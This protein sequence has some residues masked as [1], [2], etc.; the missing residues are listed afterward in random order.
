MPDQ[1]ASER[2]EQA[3]PERL[4]KAR[5]EGQVPLSREVPSALMIGALLILLSL[6]AGRLYRWFV[7]QVSGGFSARA[8][9]ALGSTHLLAILRDEAA[10]ML[11]VLL[12]FLA[13]TA[14]VSVFASLLSSGWTFA[15]K[16]VQ[17]RF[18]RISPVR[19]LKNLFSAR[20][21]VR[22]VLSILKLVFL[23]VIVYLYLRDKLGACYALRW[24]TAAGAVAGMAQLVFGLLARIALGILVIAAIDL[25]YQR[26]K[27]KRDLRMTKQEVKEERRQYELSPEVKGRIRGVQIEMVRR[28][29]LQEVPKA[30]VVLTNP[31]HVAV[32]L[33]YDAERM[34]A[35]QVVAKGA[36][37]L[38]EKIKEI[39]RAHRV[40]IRHRPE[41]A[42]ALYAT[43]EVG[44]PI[45]EA[46]FVAV[47]EILAMI[48]R[49]RKQRS[50]V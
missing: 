10:E 32:A 35:P 3:T 40:P 24:T 19:G 21:V 7:V 25:L 20:S 46:L 36:D 41:L 50:G 11:V 5:E 1:P 42:R 18:H 12:P 22:L 47:A 34:E 43:V 6:L 29:M 31:T 27:H 4:R 9:G 26:W 37:H 23:G 30:D 38:A 15:P 14:A 13:A 8:G 45:P 44:Q 16:A 39:A 28:R 49:L 48:Y 33:R 17:L 2:T